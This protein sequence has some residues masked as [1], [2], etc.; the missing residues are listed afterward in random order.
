[1]VGCVINFSDGIGLH[2]SELVGFLVSLGL[3]HLLVLVSDSLDHSSA[4]IV[5][6]LLGLSE[7]AGQV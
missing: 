2:H 3:G 7:E 4:S 1:M 5:V 6:L